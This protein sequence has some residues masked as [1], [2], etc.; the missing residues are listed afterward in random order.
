MLEALRQSDVNDE[1]TEGG[2]PDDESSNLLRTSDLP[3]GS[4]GA[5]AVGLRS[6]FAQPLWNCILKERKEML[7]LELNE[8]ENQ[9][10]LVEKAVNRHPENQELRFL[11]QALRTAVIPDTQVRVRRATRQLPPKQ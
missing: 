5:P 3:G 8:L 11:E 4:E 2:D 6:R 10:Q 1:F 9:L 7:E